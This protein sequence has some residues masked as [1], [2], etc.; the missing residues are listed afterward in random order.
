MLRGA[1][2]SHR[3]MTELALTPEALEAL[4]KKH[5][6]FLE[7]RL[8]EGAARE[9]WT[10]SFREGYAWALTLRVRDVLD[11]VALTDGVAKALTADSVKALF[12]PASRDIHRRVLAAMKKDDSRL[13]DYVPAEARLAIDELLERSDLVPER[14]VRNIFD[15]EAIE[16]AIRDTL[17]DGLKEF[18]EGVNPFFA[19]WGLPAILKR[20]PIG[21]GT[22]LKSMGAMRGEFDK[23]LDPEIRKFLLTFSRKAKVKLAD[24]FITK[25]GDPKSIELRKNVVS[26]LYSQSLK[27]LLAGVDDEASRKSEIAAE[28]I[29]LETLRRD[30][31][32]ERLR[33]GIE[34][35]LKEHGD[36]TFGEWLKAAGAASEP[37]L[38]AWASLLWPHVKRGLASPVARAFFA[39]VTSEFY[40]GIANGTV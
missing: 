3:A 20:M 11:P 13:G 16:E 2:L 32:R 38:D 1:V 21:G 39:K 33:E 15:Q 35:F 26:F 27:E 19:D 5:I 37:D 31:P 36:G 12:A 34:A 10:R 29:A 14:L 6:A 30:V 28:H 4:K 25:G 7:T 22:I 8:G 24:F 9:D 17:Y 18:N 40:D 23:R